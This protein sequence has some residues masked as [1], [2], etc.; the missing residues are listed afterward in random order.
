M[1]LKQLEIFL[2]VAETGSFSQGAE[3]TFLTQSTVS[4]HISSLEN[5]FGIKLL[6]RTGK[7]ALLTDGGKIL[8]RHARRVLAEIQAL[9][10]ALQG[11]KGLQNAELRIGGS[12]IPGNYMIPAILPTLLE[13]FPG[14][15]LTLIQGDSRDILDKLAKEEIELGIVGSRF[16]E[17]GFDFTPLGRDEICMVVNNRHPWHGMKSIDKGKLLNEPLILREAGS[18]TGRAVSDALAMAG[19]PV[20]KLKVTAYLGSNEAVKLAVIG[21]LGISFV[22]ELSIRMELEHD[23][24]SVVKVKGV[25]IVRHFYLASRTGRELSP[26]AKAFATVMRQKYC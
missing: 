16:V 21:G 14:L 17:K 12:N 1:N 8:F 10:H 22:S 15:R 24:L 18:G 2:A 9:E 26:A 5:T 11:F 3:K 4:Q 13:Q 25:R 7:G 20:G 19:L 23:E 6:D